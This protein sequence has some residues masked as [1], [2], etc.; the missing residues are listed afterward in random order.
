M[1]AIPGE[2]PH[3]LVVAD[4]N[5]KKIRNVVRKMRTE[6]R[7]TSLLKDVKIRKTIL[8]KSN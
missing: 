6:R 4:G 2:C 7:N 1:K 5:K 8:R 3:V